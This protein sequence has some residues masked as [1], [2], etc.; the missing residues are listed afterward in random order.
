MAPTNKTLHPVQWY[1][2]L[3][4]ACREGDEPLLDLVLKNLEDCTLGKE[5]PLF[6]S[7]CEPHLPIVKKLLKRIPQYATQAFLNRI[8]PNPNYTPLTTSNRGKLFKCILPH[9]NVSLELDPDSKNSNWWSYAI[10]LMTVEELE[11]IS[12]CTE[13]HKHVYDELTYHGLR[14]CWEYFN[15]NT[16]DQITKKVQ[17]VMHHNLLS[18]DSMKKVFDNLVRLDHMQSAFTIAQHLPNIKALSFTTVDTLLRS[19]DLSQLHEICSLLTKHNLNEHECQSILENL[20]NSAYRINLLE[21]GQVSPHTVD[22][23]YP[24]MRPLATAGKTGVLLSVVKNASDYIVK[25]LQTDFPKLWDWDDFYIRRSGNASIAPTPDEVKTLISPLRRVDYVVAVINDNSGRSPFFFNLKASEYHNSKVV[26]AILGSGNKALVNK[27]LF[28][29]GKVN[30]YE[31][32]LKL[33][34]W[35]D[36]SYFTE[37]W[38]QSGSPIVLTEKDLASNSV[39]DVI[40]CVLKSP[41]TH[42]FM[43]EDKAK[44]W[45]ENASDKN[46]VIAAKVAAR[47]KSPAF[48]NA[49]L[50]K[51]ALDLDDELEVLSASVNDLDTL[52]VAVQYIDPHT[53]NSQVLSKAANKNCLE[54]VKFLIPL[55]NPKANNSAALGIAAEK[56][57]IEIV[58]TLIPVSSPKDYGSRALVAAVDQQHVDVALM[59]WPHS[60]PKEARTFVDSPDFFDKCAAMWQKSQIERSLPSKNRHSHKKLRKI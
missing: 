23:I 53:E 42:I 43:N 18:E 16:S 51:V 34:S 22:V 55:C 47:Q 33:A 9:F 59:L 40:E 24:F 48:L 2:L 7:M 39:G 1:D 57:N 29:G 28:E 30:G 20:D 3:L 15:C 8:K 41:L 17:W 36:E 52:K 10:F 37:I 11:K 35:A 58:K 21:Y 6:L 44:Q 31:M 45:V 50:Q 14:W 49:A 38:K 32:W 56:G 5:L 60:I 27:C 54:A 13:N 19:K 46:L 4:K 12:F 25:K 26:A